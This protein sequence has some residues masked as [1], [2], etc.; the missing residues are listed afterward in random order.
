VLDLGGEDSVREPVVRRMMAA[1]R[2]RGP[3][4]AGCHLE[5]GVGLGFSRLAILDLSPEGHQP[6][7]NEDG[8]LWLVFNGEV[9]NFRELTPALERSG[10]R[11]R[12]HCDSEVIPHAYEEWGSACLERLNGMFAFALWDRRRREVLLARDR[13]GVKPLYYW[14]DGRTLAF[15][16][17]LKAL[18]AHPDVPRTLDHQALVSYLLHEYVP[19]PRSIFAG[20]RKLPA[21]HFLRVP[22]DGA[23][24]GR[25]TEDWRPERYWDVRFGGETEGGRTDEDYA[26]ELRGLLRAA[27]ARRL[28][29]DVPLGVFLSG[30]LDS[31]S[32]VAL[33][34]ELGGERPR[35]FAIGFEEAS[36]DELRYAEL[37]A[38]H[39]DTDHHV[40]I[41]R[42]DARE[43]IATVADYL[44]E[45][46]ADA[47][48]LPTYLVARHAREHVTVALSGDGGDEL[49][50]GYDWYAAQRAAAASVDRLPGDLRARMGA[51]A[52]HI[53]PAP[54]KKGPLNVARRF[55]EG[56]ALPAELQHVRW[57]TFWSAAELDALLLGDGMPALADD[58]AATQALLADSGSPRPLD[59]QQYA[60]IKDYLPD[61]I[62]FKVDRM[63]MAASL[64]ARGP[65]LDYTLVEFAARLPPALRRR[66]LN[67]KRLL[68]LAMRKNLPPDILR[69]RKLGFNIPYKHWLRGDLRDLLLDALAPVQL[70]QQAIF[71]PA[72]V[73]RLVR[74]HLDG[75][76]DH[77]HKLWQLLMFQL[78]AERF[79]VGDRGRDEELNMRGG[80]LD[81]N[82]IH[83]RALG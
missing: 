8:A 57:R 79:L 35:T 6:M 75:T 49:F 3:D 76:R 15:A 29:S 42:P 21:G 56:A 27:V 59:Q 26:D 31:S 70:G 61:D 1:Q 58:R 2:H 45:P 54:T 52:G 37:V 64:E 5:P 83:L 50:A 80:M 24:R 82:E 55:L 44:D 81:V 63:S 23:A 11:F 36:F 53:P 4:D 51:L 28:V 25:V 18:L 73:E 78:W 77:A 30:G 71:R 9:Y 72:A 38:R 48:A 12:S 41:L 20:V 46:F 66:G 32:V 60:D 47:S 62:L 69:R 39:F 14:S 19:S 16:S 67:G 34:A 17:E 7:T 65:F 74:E 10:H 68:K 13:L 33:M 40:A 43:L 22:L